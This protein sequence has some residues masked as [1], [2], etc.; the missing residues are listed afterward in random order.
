MVTQATPRTHPLDP[1]SAV[2]IVRASSII[3]EHFGSP[4]SLRFLLVAA[5][6]PA[7]GGVDPPRRAE[8]VCIDIDSGLTT[9]VVVDLNAGGPTSVIE[10]PG[11]QPPAL[12]EEYERAEAA[13][14]A[15]ENWHSAMRGRGLSDQQIDLSFIHLW[16][17][18]NFGSR[19]ETE[20]RILKGI[21]YLRD[22]PD[23]NAYGRPVEGLIAVVDLAA[24]RVLEVIDAPSPV[25]PVT[26]LRFDHDHGGPHREDLKPLDI[27]QSEGPSFTLEGHLLRWQQWQMRVS[28]HP[29][30]GLVLHQIGYE[31]NG[32]LRPICYRASLAEMVVPYGDASVG[33][34]FKN[35][36]DSGECGIGRL[37]NSLEL[38][39]DCLG[40]IT[41]LDGVVTDERGGARTIENAICIHEEDVGLLWKHT[42]RH[43]DERGSQ[44]WLRR[45]RRLVIS[46]IATVDNYDYGFYWYF[47]Q[48][49]AWEH[50][51]KATGIVQTMAI[52]DDDPQVTRHKIGQRLAGVHHQHFLSYRLDM[53]VD[54]RQNTVFEVDTVPLPLGPE[55]PYHNAFTAQAT[56]IADESLSGREVNAST[57]R[58]WR[59]AND[60]VRNPLGEPP[61]YVLT[62]GATVSMMADEQ[63]IIA[64]RAAFAR[65]QLW[66]TAYDSA[67]RYPAGDYPA[68]SKPG[69]GI[70]EWIDSN[71]SL[72][73]ADV[74]LWYTVGMNHL[75]RPE[76]WPVMPV[77]RA[78]FSLKPWGFFDRN[79]GLDVPQ[80]DHCEHDIE[81]RTDL[82][83]HHPHNSHS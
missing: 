65:K 31:D 75:V 18:G 52:E 17:T 57:G 63:S 50:E 71:R 68:Q 81:R 72:E 30:E 47:Y 21:V 13:I 64:Q 76:D 46:T 24:N 56:P 38:G 5:L 32:Q 40:E 29:R 43:P 7:K 27:I 14:R 59:I 60:S 78:G 83:A 10:L 36:F 69:L 33:H 35:A 9:E 80:P 82:Q 37:V 70:P 22:E 55:N 2:E 77:Q 1:L 34:Y 8:A 28:L 4:D 3:S 51:V 67:Q 11:V 58:H 48:D 15:D 19:W 6:E 42:Y 16:P 41:Y 45:S 61:A 20:H 26:S 39:C 49:G 73:Q 79:P 74:V 54:G 25:P 44:S 23:D 53:E 66:V 62:P 12:F